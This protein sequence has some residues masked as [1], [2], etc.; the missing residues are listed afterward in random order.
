MRLTALLLMVGGLVLGQTALPDYA[1]IEAKIPYDQ[2]PETVLDVISPKLAGQEKRP[3]VVAIHGGGWVQ[4]S[5]EAFLE[6]VLPWVEK[7]FVLANIE[8]RLAGVAP[9]PA[10]AT[11]ALKAVEWFR[12]NAKRWNV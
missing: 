5:K 11:D 8:Y 9:A 4:G 12:K 7:G 3:G 1:K 2:Y 6:S 10:A